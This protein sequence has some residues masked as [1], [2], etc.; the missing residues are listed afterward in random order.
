MYQKPLKNPWDKN[1]GEVDHKKD[2]KVNDEESLTENSPSP[3][4]TSVTSKNHHGNEELQ[5]VTNFNMIDEEEVAANHD[6][7][8]LNEKSDKELKQ[9][10]KKEVA[11][12][13][14]IDE[15][16]V[17]A[18]H[19]ADI[20]NEKSGK[21]L[22]QNAEKEVANKVQIDEEE[23]AAN[24]D[25]DIL[26]EESDRNHVEK[27]KEKDKK[28]IAVHAKNIET[29]SITMK[30]HLINFSQETKDRQKIHTKP[31]FDGGK[32]GYFHPLEKYI[33]P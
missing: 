8:I 23:V 6:A 5:T 15:E 29:P 17:A 14:Q 9:N 13:V 1:K 28:K 12:K 3:F 24:H 21:E 30:N 26:K 27:L 32:I 31:N 11:N 18:N 7:D 2:K 10:D 33:W 20:L 22:K 19:D 16:E 4:P 25:A